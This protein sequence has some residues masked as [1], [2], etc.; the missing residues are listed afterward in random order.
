M[1]SCLDYCLEHDVS[2]EIHKCIRDT[3]QRISKL[4]CHSSSSESKK[5]SP[6]CVCVCHGVC[7][8]A[9]HVCIYIYTHTWIQTHT[10][11][12]IMISAVYTEN[13]WGHWRKSACTHK[14]TCITPSNLAATWASFSTPALSVC[15][16]CDAN[17]SKNGIEKM[18]TGMTERPEL[19]NWCH[20]LEQNID[21]KRWYACCQWGDVRLDPQ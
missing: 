4:S 6:V 13:T 1:Y 20:T 2:S 16:P 8:C 17:M 14:R 21:Y 9:L 18:K 3:R 5:E 15:S 19:C 7:V 10:C 11:M 12:H